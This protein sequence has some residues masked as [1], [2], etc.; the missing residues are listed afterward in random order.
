MNLQ[1]FVVKNNDDIEPKVTFDSLI[2]DKDIIKFD[3][4]IYFKRKNMD[5]LSIYWVYL[6]DMDTKQILNGKYNSQIFL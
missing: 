5:E 4:G 6:V 3:L 2:N 1:V